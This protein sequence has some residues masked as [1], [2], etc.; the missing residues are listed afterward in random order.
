MASGLTVHTLQMLALL[1]LMSVKWPGSFDATSPRLQFFLLDMEDLRLSCP[2]GRRPVTKYL[3]TAS[4]FPVALL[5]LA[6]CHVLSKCSCLQKWV[7][8]WKL[9]FTLNTMGLG[10]S[11]GLWCYFNSSFE[12]SNVLRA[13]EWTGEPGKLPQHILRR[14]VTI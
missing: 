8:A 12:T 3:V 11:V 2:L 14:R 1:G 9:A 4:A 7:K 13:S 10:I 5:W 6:V